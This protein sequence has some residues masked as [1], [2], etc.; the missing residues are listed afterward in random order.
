MSK[1]FFSV[2]QRALALFAA[3]LTDPEVREYLMSIGFPM[4]WL[5][6]GNSMV[7][8][9]KG[10][11]DERNLLVSR[12]KGIKEAIAQIWRNVKGEVNEFRE[13]WRR[14]AVRRER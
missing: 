5:S 2:L 10:A 13:G 4:D 6:Q 12:R 1:S 9:A 11:T 7:E 3:V 8:R 14:G